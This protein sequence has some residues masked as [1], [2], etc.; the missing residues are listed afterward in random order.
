MEFTF[1]ATNIGQTTLT[2][3]VLHSSSVNK[4]PPDSGVVNIK[5]R[6][7]DDF[8]TQRRI[9]VFVMI[10]ICDNLLVSKSGK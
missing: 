4:S 6:H 2:Q 5:K 3:L 10:C 9:F 1:V 7:V 8:F